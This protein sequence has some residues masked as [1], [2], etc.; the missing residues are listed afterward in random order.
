MKP[1]DWKKYSRGCDCTTCRQYALYELRRLRYLDD[2]DR[3]GPR[4]GKVS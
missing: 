1:C 3:G 4:D 2:R